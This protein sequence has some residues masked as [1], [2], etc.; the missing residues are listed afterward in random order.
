M[1][2]MQK[3]ITKMW[4]IIWRLYTKMLLTSASKIN[5]HIFDSVQ[6]TKLHIFN[7]VWKLKLHIFNS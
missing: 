6:T 2:S 3:D 7:S 5:L 1:I 4:I